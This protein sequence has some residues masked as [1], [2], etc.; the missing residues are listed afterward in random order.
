MSLLHPLTICSAMPAATP[1]AMLKAAGK[2]SSPAPRAALTTMKTA[3]KADV[4]PRP[5]AW[6][7]PLFGTVSTLGLCRSLARSPASA[8]HSQSL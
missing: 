3:P 8:L 5:F 6:L 4:A 1:P 2:L 7:S